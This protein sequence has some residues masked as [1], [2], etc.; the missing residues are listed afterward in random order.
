MDVRTDIWSMGVVLYEII[1]S[2]KPFQ[3]DQGSTSRKIISEAHP[4]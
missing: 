3:G 1:S 2:R 4:L